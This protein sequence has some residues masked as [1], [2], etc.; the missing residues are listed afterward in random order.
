M[1]HG[2]THALP[3]A[4][5]QGPVPKNGNLTGTKLEGKRN[6][7]SAA[8][9]SSGSNGQTGVRTFLRLPY[10]ALSRLAPIGQ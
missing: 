5:R 10:A 6:K 1:R 9:D 8:L 4:L 7:L 2:V 3:S